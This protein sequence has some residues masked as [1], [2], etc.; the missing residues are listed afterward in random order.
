LKELLFTV[1]KESF[2]FQFFRAGGKGGQKQNK[3][4]SGC[5]CVHKDSGAV[6]EGRD[7]RYQSV[8]KV[9]A[10]MRCVNS[11]K[12]Q[13]WLKLEIARHQGM[14]DE[15]QRAVDKMMQPVNIK[16]EY[17]DNESVI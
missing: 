14:E 16:I 13:S 9:N 3:T 6:G 5:R 2:E 11:P 10:F 8:N 15:V 1:K 12:F 17:F 4:S 7:E